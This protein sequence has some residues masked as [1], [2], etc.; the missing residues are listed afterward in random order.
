MDRPRKRKPKQF[1]F[2]AG[3]AGGAIV[4]PSGTWITPSIGATYGDLGFGAELSY[5]DYKRNFTGCASSYMSPGDEDVSER[6]SFIRPAAY[7]EYRLDYGPVVIIPKATLGY[8]GMVVKRWSAEE[9]D[10]KKFERDRLTN[11]WE[12]SV[13]MPVGPVIIGATAQWW[14]INPWFYFYPEDFGLVNVGIW[15]KL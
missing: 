10:T 12:L 6:G 2:S 8:S 3:L 7:A 1:N 5:A 4:Y 9:P 13:G 14:V 15:L 11:T